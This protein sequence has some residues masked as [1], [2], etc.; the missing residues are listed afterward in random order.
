MERSNDAQ[1]GRIAPLRR[2]DRSGTST[3]LAAIPLGPWILRGIVS[4]LLAG[5]VYLVLITVVA[6]AQGHGVLYGLKSVY[7]IFVG[8]RVLPGVSQLHY[9]FGAMG[10]VAA[11]AWLAVLSAAAGGVFAALTTRRQ[12]AARLT[13]PSLVALGVAWLLVLFLLGF[14]L[15]GYE[16]GPL[17]QRRVSSFEGVR[18]IGGVVFLVAHLLFGVVLGALLAM[19]PRRRRG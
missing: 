9:R 7:A 15:L 3:P 13:V 5:V 18:E 16:A 12:R 14:V 17:L 19:L 4:G 2:T 1:R 6:L 10:L 11:L 8:S